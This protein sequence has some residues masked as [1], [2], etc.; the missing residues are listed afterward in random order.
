MRKI[1]VIFNI[2]FL[3]TAPQIAHGDENPVKLLL[4]KKIDERFTLLTQIDYRH[5][6]ETSRF[7][8]KHYDVGLR[9]NHKNNWSTSFSYRW[10]YKF[11]NGEKKWEQEKR[12]Y[13]SII[14]KFKTDPVTINLRARQEFRFR[15]GNKHSTRNRLRLLLKSNKEF[16]GVRPFIANE[17]FYDFRKEKYNKNF[18]LAGID[19]ANTRYGRYSIYYRHVTTLDKDDKRYWSAKGGVSFKALYY[20]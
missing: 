11:D 12:P 7:E 3:L 9:I 1:F 2:L 10:M 19:F 15:K 4:R 5:D 20:F 17:I 8:H 16:V 13:I 14:K 6:D 18:L